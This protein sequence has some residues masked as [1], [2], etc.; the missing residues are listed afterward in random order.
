MCIRDRCCHCQFNISIPV[1]VI[2]AGAAGLIAGLAAHGNGAQVL[3]VERDA[4]PTGSTALSSGLIPACNTRWQAASKVADN[5]ETFSQDIRHKNKKQADE[6]L[7]DKSCSVSGEVLHWLADNHGQNFDLI[8]GFL[9]PGHSV[10]PVSY[11]HLT[12]PTILRV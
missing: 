2:G 7:V 9:Y 8:E 3:I 12:L 6:L 1:V 11:T 4:N 10:H 5:V